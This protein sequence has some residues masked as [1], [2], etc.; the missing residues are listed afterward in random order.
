MER[1]GEHDPLHA[2]GAGGPQHAQRSLARG[3]DHVVF[4][5]DVSG[6]HRRCDVQHEVDVGHRVCPSLVAH[7]VSGDEAQILPVDHS[8][9]V[10]HGPHGRF[11]AQ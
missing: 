2:G 4:V 7:E 11:L 6:L 5:L 8:S 10:E 9:V 1:R 3:D